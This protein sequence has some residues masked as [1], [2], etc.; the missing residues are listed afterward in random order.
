[1]A[2]TMGKGEFIYEVVE[3]WGKLPDGWS[4]RE[5]AAVGVDRQD[6]VYLF[7]RG[8][9]PIIVFDRDGS[10]LRS[11]GEGLF[12]RAHGITMGPDD[13]INPPKS[14][15][16]LLYTTYTSFALSKSPGPHPQ[17]SPRVTRSGGPPRRGPLVGVLGGKTVAGPWGEKN[18][19]TICETRIHTIYQI[20]IL[21]MPIPLTVLAVIDGFGYSPTI[22]GNAIAATRTPTLDY[23]WS[24]FPHFLVKAAEEEVG[25]AF[26]EVGNSE[27]GHI[28]IG[29]GRVV[30]QSLALINKAV[31]DGTFHQNPAFLLA[32]NQVKQSGRNLHILGIIST[33]GVHGHLYHI[34]ELIKLA[35][36]QGITNLYLDLILDGRDS[37]P[38]D[39]PLYLREINAA[40]SGAKLGRIATI[41][42]R[43]FTMDRHDNWERTQRAYQVLLGQSE[44]TF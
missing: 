30:P 34:L 40:L 4:Y 2:T 12:K 25:L 11:W 16:S 9:H 7:S 42:G 15:H 27:V 21:P 20:P 1:M 36:E 23:L 8:E 5:V 29:T 38:R 41:A 39:S 31:E 14:S 13:S 24:H 32:I 22:E 10:F 33:P 43:A 3:G 19:I 44:Q 17:Y 26:G 6:R 37:G 18:F 35:A 28:A